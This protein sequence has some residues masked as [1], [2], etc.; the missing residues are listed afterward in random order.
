MQG[1]ILR[2]LILFSGSSPP[3]APPSLCSSSCTEGKQSLIAQ[4]GIT[5]VT[6]FSPDD[7]R[8]R[9][10]TAPGALLR[11]SV[12]EKDIDDLLIRYEN[13]G[14]PLAKVRVDSLR[15]DSLD[16]SRLSLVLAVTEGPRVY[17]TELKVEGN[18]LTRWNVISREAYL[19]PFEIYDQE[20]VDGIRKRL[21]RLGIF[22][23][24]AEPQLYLSH[25]PGSADTVSGGLTIAVHE[26]NTNSFDGIVGYVP[27][28]PG[29]ASGYF[30]GYVFVSMKNLF[31]TGRRIVV[32]WQRETETTQ[33][34]EATYNEPWV[35]GLPVNAG[36][37]ILQ[38]KQ[39]SSVHQ[40][41]VR[42]SGGSQRHSRA[43]RRRHVK[44]GVGCS[45][46]KFDVF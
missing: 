41:E 45:L 26:G 2:G 20:K 12:L 9:F 36:V 5:G 23:S 28:L 11:Q 7:V 29:E 44:P 4:I 6:A 25:D 13:S 10:E 31:G 24:V 30:T 33:E 19:Q 43:V 18:S 35:A 32:R 1:S 21:E 42:C 46:R 37:G 17:L 15:V 8:R 39:D 3:T 40:D 16:T 22:S 14:Y 27:P 38:R 34:L